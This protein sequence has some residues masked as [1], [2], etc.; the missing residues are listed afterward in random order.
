[1]IWN[2]HNKISFLKSGLRIIGFIFLPFN[3]FPSAVLLVLAEVFGVL[4]E[5][6]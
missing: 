4:E 2:W 1:M 6:W 3:L 5:L